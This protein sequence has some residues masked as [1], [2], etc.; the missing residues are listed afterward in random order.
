MRDDFMTFLLAGHDT[1]GATL[2]WA[3]YLLAS[4]PATR[5][6]AQEELA[7]RVGSRT[8]SVSDLPQLVF[9]RQV[10]DETLRLYPPVWLLPRRA[11]S[12]DCI[13]GF[14]V[15]AGADVLVHIYGMHRHPRLWPEPQSFRPERFHQ[16][17][18]ESMR[19][20][21]FM[22]FGAGARACIGGRFGMNEAML[23]LAVLLQRFN[24]E[25][26]SDAEPVPD[27]ALTL[28]PRGGMWLRL[29]PR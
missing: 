17:G 19:S 3:L 11:I 10:V 23:V 5:A 8:P 24:P 13:R 7:G 15:P 12:A 9:L 20:G 1:T 28:W 14:H 2:T 18:P 16:R 27:D 4:H 22:P 26:I 6:L 25:L 29:C 21:G